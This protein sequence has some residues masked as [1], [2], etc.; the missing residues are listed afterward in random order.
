M[1]SLDSGGREEWKWTLNAT[2]VL[3]VGERRGTNR[4]ASV[5]YLSVWVENDKQ[6][7]LQERRIISAYSFRWQGLVLDCIMTI[8]SDTM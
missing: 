1:T 4:E 8:H 2:P 7:T 3:R 6:R 5:F